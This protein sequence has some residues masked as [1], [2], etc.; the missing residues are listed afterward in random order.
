MYVRS[1]LVYVRNTLAIAAAGLVFSAMPAL[2][3]F[4]AGQAAF[5]RGDHAAALAEWLPL[6]HQG[7]PNAQFN[8]SVILM[9]GMAGPRNPGEAA[10]WLRAAARQGVAPAQGALGLMLLRGDGLPQDIPE[11]LDMLTRAANAG[12]GEAQLALADMYAAGRYVTADRAKALAWYDR[13]AANPAP[14]V[15]DR[16][17]DRRDRLV[18]SSQQ[19]QPSAR[20]QASAPGWGTGF[21]VTEAGH[22]LTAQHVVA[23]CKRLSFD[24]A[25]RIPAA[26]VSG[27]PVN[28]L[29][30]LKLPA[31]AQVPGVAALR[32]ARDVR[33]G[34][35]VQIV[36]FNAEPGASARPSLRQGLV[37]GMLGIN[38]DS[39]FLR[40]NG[41]ASPGD[42]G[43]P[44]VDSDGR[45]LAVV[46]SGLNERGASRLPAPQQDMFFALKADLVGIFLDSSGIETSAAGRSLKPADFTM[47]VAC[48]R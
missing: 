19:P 46:L 27:D 36:G 33:P 14:T 10:R 4:E 44:L 45:V 20:A 6:A 21:V 17:R 40:V 26:I 5:R 22:V 2:A 7:D 13:A 35:A 29:A 16:A 24:M 38:R 15:A 28:D 1:T 41:K 9:H 42:S 3:D 12:D 30:L 39:R 11:G 25:G 31:N 37:T 47:P 18:A 34:T 32:S 43:G 8:V 23:G 48:W